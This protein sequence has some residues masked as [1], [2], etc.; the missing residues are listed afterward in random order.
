M[1]K[2]LYILVLFLPF[3]SFAQLN[4]KDANGKK[5]GVWQK[6]IQE[7]ILLFTK[8]NLKMTR[9][10]ESLLIIMKAEK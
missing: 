2:L 6:N 1:K 10:L 3:L 5:Q 7:V 8:V 9:Q 4:Q